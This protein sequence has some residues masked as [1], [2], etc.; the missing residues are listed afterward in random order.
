MK[1]KT[2]KLRLNHPFLLG[3]NEDGGDVYMDE[4][5]SM[6]K[7]LGSMLEEYAQ[8][9]TLNRNKVLDL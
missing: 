2:R 1:A 5:E 8:Q 4:D 3:E 9:S 6:F 7:V